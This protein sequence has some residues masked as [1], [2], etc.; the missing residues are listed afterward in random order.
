M[1]S[2]GGVVLT[3]FWGISLR[4]GIGGVGNLLGRNIEIRQWKA[5]KEW[6]EGRWKWRL[7]DEVDLYEK[8]PL[9][10]ALSSLPRLGDTAGFWPGHKAWL[11]R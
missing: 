9:G 2:R 6:Q 4:G 1:G 3:G 11:S 5:I 8:M 10:V 7:S